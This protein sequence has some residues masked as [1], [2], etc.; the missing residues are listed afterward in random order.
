[1]KRLLLL[2]AAL[3]LGCA[4]HAAEKK[5]FILYATMLEP[6]PVQLV[7][8]SKWM[9]DKGDTFPVVMFKE[10]QTQVVLQLAGT[11]FKTAT[12][13]VKVVEE[14]DVTPEQLATY[15]T[16]VQNYIDSRS[17]KWKAEQAK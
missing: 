11:T 7:D 6:T 1:V 3:I 17:E 8:G 14:K 4:L 2:L 5:R 15:R 10:Q 9:M 13:R 16:N 12:A